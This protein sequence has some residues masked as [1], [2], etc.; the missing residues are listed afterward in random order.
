MPGS[1]AAAGP[2][3]AGGGGGGACGDGGAGRHAGLPR[4]RPALRGPV[5]RCPGL[6]AR[7][8]PLL[9]LPAWR[10]LAR[11]RLRVGLVRRDR[12]L[13]TGRDIGGRGALECRLTAPQQ[14]QEACLVDIEVAGEAG[15]DAGGEH[16]LAALKLP[17]EIEGLAGAPDPPPAG[18]RKRAALKGIDP[19]PARLTELQHARLAVVDHLVEES[20]EPN[21][22]D[23][24][25]R[26]GLGLGSRLPFALGE[27]LHTAVTGDGRPSLP[28]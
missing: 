11:A 9:R 7:W 3:R 8:R 28:V 10:R 4:R 15:V 17:E 19:V 1:Q 25:E 22:I 14:I 6:L 16:E 20:E 12:S 18:V 13:L 23:G 2:G 5:G 24:A 21:S 26:R 27:E